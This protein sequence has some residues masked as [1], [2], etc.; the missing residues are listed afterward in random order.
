[1]RLVD[2]VHARLA[3]AV[4]PGDL[5]VDAT[6]GNGHDTLCLARR[7]GETGRVF[8]IDIQTEALEATRERLSDAGAL[9]RIAFA[10]GDHA[11]V[12]DAMLQNEASG[13]AAA[14]VFNLGYLPGGDPSVAT[15][16]EN[17]ERALGAASELLRPGGLLAVVAYTGHDEGPEEAEAVREWMERLR[18]ANGWQ[19][20]RVDPQE[21]GEAPPVAWFARR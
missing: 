16:A 10:R 2:H 13:A 17:T 15:R 1:M 11:G 19:V 5:A 12:L 14:V 3:Q 9:E 8:A 18:D 6:A 20:E 7:V 4:A 21:G